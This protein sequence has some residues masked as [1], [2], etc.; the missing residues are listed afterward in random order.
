MVCGHPVTVALAL[1]HRSAVRVEGAKTGR[2]SA[3]I[4]LSTQI[5]EPSGTPGL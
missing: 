3:E 4:Q 1:M 2:G 5:L